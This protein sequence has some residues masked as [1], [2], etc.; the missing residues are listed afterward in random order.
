MFSTP[1][2]V[3]GKQWLRVASRGA[4]LPPFYRRFRDHTAPVALTRAASV[5]WTRGGVTPVASA[6]FEGQASATDAKSDVA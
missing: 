2:G 3:F 6:G 4:G 5:Q 1:E